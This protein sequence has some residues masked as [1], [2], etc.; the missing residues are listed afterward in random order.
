MRMKMVLRKEKS[1]VLR[2]GLTKASNK[3]KK[4]VFKMN[5]IAKALGLPEDATEKQILDA[6][7][8]R[9]ESIEAREKAVIDRYM[10]LGEKVGLVNEKNKEKMQR[11][12][13][14][15]FDLFVDMIQ[16]PCAETETTEETLTQKPDASQ[17]LSDVIKKVPA[18]TAKNELDH[19]YDWYQK[20][21]PEALKDMEKTDPKKFNRLLDEY[22]RKIEG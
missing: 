17:R 18:A 22:E 14:A 7:K 5:E 21:N 10:A 9:K 1:K 4:K 20:H 13:A 6:I 19:D 16:D 3:A 11:L 12:A 8:A 2:R 15:D